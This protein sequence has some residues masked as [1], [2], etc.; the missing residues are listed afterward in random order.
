MKYLDEYPLFLTKVPGVDQEFDL[1]TLFGRQEY[2]QAK[3]GKKIEA[4]R[5]HIQEN[6]FIAYLLAKKSAGKGTY[7]KQMIEIFGENLIGHIS[8][9]DTVRSAGKEI[10]TAEGEQEMRD[11]MEIHYRGFMSLDDAMDALAGRN[12]Q[13]LLP[14]EFTLAL[15]KRE[16]QKHGRKVLFI[17][18]FPRGVDQ[19][20]YT[21]FFRDLIDFRSDPDMF[22]AIDIPEQVI[23]ERMKGRVVCPVCQK[24]N[25]LRTLPTE[26][27]GQDNETGE[28][29]LMCDNPAC[30]RARMGSKD[31]DTAGV[32]SIR[33]RLDRDGALIDKIFD[34]HG[35]SKIVLRNALPVN[36]AEQYADPYELTLAYSYKTND[37][38]SVEM[39]TE[40]FEVTDDEG[41][42]VVSVIGAAVVLQLLDQLYRVLE[43]DNE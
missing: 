27:V 21:L 24:P 43:L 29:Y 30:D 23:E 35:I 36:E 16:I 34:L 26:F 9:G 8:V 32:E 10:E 37:D 28:Y 25:N 1:N 41:E 5:N 31:G 2:F 42:Q 4:I 13:T 38:S 11:Y 6:T 7:T 15:L 40:P 14:T 18:G 20:S 33:E 22:I 3:A 19:M 17:D 39:I 12:Q